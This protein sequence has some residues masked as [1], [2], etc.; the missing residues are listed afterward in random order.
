[1]SAPDPSAN[2][3]AT[4]PPYP[5]PTP[6]DSDALF[7]SV[8]WLDWKAPPELLRQ[9]EGMHI[10]IFGE[11]IIDADRDKE[12]LFSRLDVKLRTLPPYH[13]LVRYIPTEEEAW[14]GNY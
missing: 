3:T 11:Q 14:S 2:A 10:A 5:D 1:M 4:A 7:A 12:A 6:A 8:E 9:Y 13:V